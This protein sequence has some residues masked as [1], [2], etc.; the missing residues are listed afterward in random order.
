MRIN[1]KAKKPLTPNNRT[2]HNSRLTT[3]KMTLE[4]L[5]KDYVAF[6]VWANTL[7]VNWLKSKPLELLDR[8]VPSSFPSLRSTMLH[9]WSAQDIWLRRLQGS[10]PTELVSGTFKGSN[11]EL[12]DGLLQNSMDF[13][14]FIGSRDSSYFSQKIG[15]THTTGIPYEQYTTEIIQHCMQHSTYH[16]GQIVTIARNLGLTDPPKS[17]Y[18]GFVREMR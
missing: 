9:T 15:Y 6:N 2:T 1:K 14:D 8:E 4:F 12:M 5:M 18:I 13:S 10:S 17:D 3:H 7:F 16:R 11:T